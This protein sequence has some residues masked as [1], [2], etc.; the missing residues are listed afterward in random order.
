VYYPIRIHIF[1]ISNLYLYPE[2][3]IYIFILKNLK[4]IQ[5]PFA[6]LILIHIMFVSATRCKLRSIEFFPLRSRSIS[7]HRSLINNL[8][9]A[10]SVAIIDL[11]D[12]SQ[13]QLVMQVYPHIHESIS[14]SVVFVY[15][16]SGVEP[17]F[18]VDGYKLNFFQAD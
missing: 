9:L 18:D 14:L 16:E 13:Q 12:C 5:I 8:K 2:L 4:R 7:S 1:L 3:S 11:I 17:Y 10:S 15:M 6:P